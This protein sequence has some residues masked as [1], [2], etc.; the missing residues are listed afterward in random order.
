[1]NRTGGAF[2]ILLIAGIV[3]LAGCAGATPGDG[4]ATGPDPGDEATVEA[5]N[6]TVEVHFINVGQSVSTLVLGPEGAAMLV[7]TGHYNDDG[8]YSA[9]GGRTEGFV[10]VPAGPTRLCPRTGIDDYDH[11]DSRATGG[12]AVGAHSV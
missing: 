11:T 9:G 7:D 8:E 4:V 10:T 2:K 5:A 12:P 1:M 6:G 3:V